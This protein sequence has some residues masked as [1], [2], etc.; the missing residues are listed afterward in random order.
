MMKYTVGPWR[1]G[2][3]N[4]CT[5]YDNLGQRVANSFE[6]VM[7][8][9]RSDAECAANARLIA[10]APEL[11]EALEECFANAQLF[12]RDTDAVWRATRDKCRAAIAKATA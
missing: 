3:S 2:G 5:I 9:Q 11:L 6:G 7:A 8:T 10:A 1:V 12:N 4:D